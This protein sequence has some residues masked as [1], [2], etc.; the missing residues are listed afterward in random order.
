MAS[1][2]RSLFLI[3][4]FAF[5]AGC[6]EQ[7]AGVAPENAQAPAAN[8]AN[9]PGAPQEETAPAEFKIDFDTSRG[10]FVVEVTRSQA[11]HGADRLYSLVRAKYFDGARFFRVVPGFMVQWGIAADPAVTNAWDRP[12]L[13][14]KVITR[15]ARGTVTFASPG[16]PNSRTTQLFINFSDNYRLDS[17]GF[18]PVGQVVSGMENVDRIYPD[19]GEYPDQ[20]QISAKGNAYLIKNYP[21]LDYIKTARIEP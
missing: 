19:Y 18:R 14:D 13:D 16:Q 3:A 5:L 4:G 7:S 1:I 8:P 21:N 20:G 10:P 15:N 2:G 6:A 11:P 17:M 9:S 12:I